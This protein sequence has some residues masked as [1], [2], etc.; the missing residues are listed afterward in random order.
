MTI[1]ALVPII[2]E[3]LQ[4]QEKSMYFAGFY[5]QDAWLEQMVVGIVEE[6]AKFR[7][8]DAWADLLEDEIHEPEHRYH[9]KCFLGAHPVDEISLQ[10]ALH[11]FSLTSDDW[12][13]LKGK[14]GG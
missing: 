12:L 5:K 1:E 6:R 7:Q 2:V 10:L 13:W 14:V 8:A 4:E 11:D 9:S 3:H